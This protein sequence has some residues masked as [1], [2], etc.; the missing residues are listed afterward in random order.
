[1]R[2]TVRLPEALLR[3][4][5]KQAVERGSTLTA[6][7]EEGLRTILDGRPSSGRKKPVAPRVSQ[8]S[9]GLISGIDWKKIADIDADD[10]LESLQRSERSR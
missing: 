10:E 2:T 3:R 1:M 4:A 7:I 5:K 8:A 6:L 9:G